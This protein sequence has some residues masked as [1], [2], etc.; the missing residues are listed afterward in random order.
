MIKNVLLVDPDPHTDRLLALEHVLRPMARVVTVV[1]FQSA[2]VRLRETPPDL[3]VTNLRL[4]AYNGIHLALLTGAIATRCVV[5]AKDHDLLLA[6][7]VQAAGAF[8]ER[9]EHLPLSVPP[10]LYVTL[11]PRDLR[12]PATPN[13]RRTLRGGRRSTDLTLLA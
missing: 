8:Y 3:L 11:P 7:Q 6:Q 5:Y 9:L 4:Q 2:R 10:Y 1:D 13:R 12:D